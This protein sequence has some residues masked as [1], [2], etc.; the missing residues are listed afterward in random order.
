MSCKNRIFSKNPVFLYSSTRKI[1]VDRAVEPSRL[2]VCYLPDLLEEMGTKP[3]PLT[4]LKPLVWKKKEK[5][6]D[7]VRQWDAEIHSPELPEAKTKILDELL[8]YAILQR[9]SDPALE[10]AKK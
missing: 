8:E 5:L 6:P 4:V 7:A 2:I 3:S 1:K 9:F 10:D